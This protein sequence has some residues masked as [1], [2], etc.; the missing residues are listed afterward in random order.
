MKKT[1]KARVIYA[2]QMEDG[3]L[4]T[5]YFTEDIS[6]AKYECDLDE[7]IV[8]FVEVLGKTKKKG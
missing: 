1:R 3:R 6:K 7:K 2:I 8:K 4:D 5:G